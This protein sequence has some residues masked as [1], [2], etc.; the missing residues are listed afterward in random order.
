MWR[1]II[2]TA[3]LAAIALVRVRITFYA[4]YVKKPLWAIAVRVGSVN[5]PE[6]NQRTTAQRRSADKPARELLHRLLNDLRGTGETRRFLLRH[7]RLEA[8]EAA[9]RIGSQDAAR[10]ALLCGGAQT[11]WSL[12]PSAWRSLGRF[13]VQ[14][15]FAGRG[16][17]GKAR[18]IIS[19]RLGTIAAAAILLLTDRMARSGRDAA[20]SKEA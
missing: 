11:A 17:A 4:A 19:F 8:L 1:A 13:S 14:P 9:L 7:V 12:L 3:L 5:L 2:L 16:T 15:D 10:T 20:R 6:I 18:C